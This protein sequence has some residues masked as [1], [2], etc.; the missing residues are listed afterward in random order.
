M[1]EGMLYR[2]VRVCADDWSEIG[3]EEDGTVG[4]SFE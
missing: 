2:D 3:R 1:I 4:N